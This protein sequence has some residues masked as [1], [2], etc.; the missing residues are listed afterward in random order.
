MIDDKTGVA[1]FLGFILE[2]DSYAIEITKVREVLDFTKIRSV[3]Q[4]PTFMRG[5]INLRGS[6]VPVMDLRVKFDMNIKENSVN[7]CIIIVE[8]PI[9]G[10]DTSIG[11]IADSVQEVMT[12]DRSNIEPAPK[13]GTRLHAEFIQGMCKHN[14]EFI[15]L[16]D[17]I[18]VFTHE[19]L[20]VL[21][22]EVR[23]TTEAS[24]EVVEKE[25]MLS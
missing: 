24:E 6:V 9:D 10:E 3:P 22:T 11:I 25:A 5:V 17:L 20:Q 15:I 21:Q 12:I 8:L 4:M 23:H 19:E 14:N 13:L 18:K 2:E 1:Q 7:T 16:L